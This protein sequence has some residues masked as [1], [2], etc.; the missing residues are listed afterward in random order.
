MFTLYTTIFLRGANTGRLMHD[1]MKFEII[2]ETQEISPIITSYDLE[3]FY[4][5]D[6]QP[7]R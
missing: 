4:Q 7:W 5:I 6:A 1:T 2:S 3:L